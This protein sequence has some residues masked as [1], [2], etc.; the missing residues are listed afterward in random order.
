M[1][2]GVPYVIYCA[3][4]VVQNVSFWT[5]DEAEYMTSLRKTTDAPSQNRHREHRI[6]TA[7]E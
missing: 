3:S 6:N 7:N 4:S 5:T 2:H 1:R